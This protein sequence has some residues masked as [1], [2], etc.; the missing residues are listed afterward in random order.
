M[1]LLVSM[2][3]LREVSSLIELLSNELPKIIPYEFGNLRWNPFDTQTEDWPGEIEDDF[4][5]T[6]DFIAN[7]GVLSEE[8][9]IEVFSHQECGLGRIWT[10]GMQ[11]VCRTRT[12][13][14]DP[15]LIKIHSGLLVPLSKDD[16]NIGTLSLFSTKEEGL[17]RFVDDPLAVSIWKGLGNALGTLIEIENAE[18]ELRRTRELLDS[19]EDLLVL[20]KSSGSF[21][22]IECNDKAERFMDRDSLSPDMMEG[23]FFAPPG[24][25]WERAMFAWRRAHNA[26]QTYQIDLELRSPN[27]ESTPYLCTFSPYILNG[28][29]SGVKMTGIETESIDKAV[30]DMGSSNKGYRLLLSLLSHDLKNPLSAIQ[31]YNELLKMTGDEKKG[32]Y[33]EKI[34]KMVERMSRTVDLAGMM[35]RVQEGKLEEEFQTMDISK[36]IRSSIE[37]LQSKAGENQIQFEQG[38]GEFT[39]QGHVFLEQVFMNLLDNA[40][41]YSPEGGR[42]DICLY[43]DLK[44]LNIEIKDQGIGIRDD[45]K[46]LIF[47]RFE[48]GN[49]T[50]HGKG[51]GLGLAISKSIIDLHGGK[52]WVENNEPTGSIFNVSLPW[53]RS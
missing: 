1:D 39:I 10:G 33:T 13:N 8:G 7:G 41:K 2:M 43:T 31:G 42:I 20:W 49:E 17:S 52:I 3:G 47:N 51:L 36:V 18:N 30:T 15:V 53:S 19:T 23:P 26:G 22:E 27:G 46:T 50:R 29:I 11:G 48:R 9:S 35:A 21:W 45:Q 6:I 38:N 16:G 25:E 37:T 40:I 4:P 24:K 12:A 34:S 14:G 44:G 5:E 28:E 32:L